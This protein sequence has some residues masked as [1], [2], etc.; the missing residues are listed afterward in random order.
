MQKLKDYLGDMLKVLN[1]VHFGEYSAWKLERRKCLFRKSTL[2]LSGYL[3]AVTGKR[4][5]EGRVAYCDSGNATT[6]NKAALVVTC[7]S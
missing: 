2:D 1:T 6:L 4:R 3:I 5:T 7:I